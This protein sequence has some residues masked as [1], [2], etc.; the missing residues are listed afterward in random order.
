MM[1]L[2]MR[3][4]WAAAL[5]VLALGCGDDDP[6]GPSGPQ[7]DGT[8][9]GDTD[10]GTLSVTLNETGGDITGT[11]LL[12]AGNHSADLT[13][14]GTLDG[15]TVEMSV[16]SPVLT[17]FDM[18]ATVAGNTMTGTIEGAGPDPVAFSFTRQ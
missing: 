7:L 10:L 18:S 14:E 9:S 13:L 1:R 11:G 3:G 17:P 4:F 2:T 8:W 16:S 5:V 6:S 15:S 12:T